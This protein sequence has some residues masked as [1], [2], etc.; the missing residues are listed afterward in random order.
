MDLIKV[1]NLALQPQRL[2]D[3][4]PSTNESRFVTAVKEPKIK[5]C[6]INNFKGI[7]RACILKVGIRSQNLPSPEEWAVLQSHALLNYGNHTCAEIS[8]AFDMAITGKLDVEVNAYESFS[9]LYFSN[10]MNAYR[11]WANQV[12]FYKERE[13]KPEQKL[14]NAP[15][16]TDDEII[17]LATEVWNTTKN[18]AFLPVKAYGALGRKGKL[19]FTDEEKAQ[20]RNQAKAHVFKMYGDKEDRISEV[21]SFAKKIAVSRVLYLINKV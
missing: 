4:K 19:N 6:D 1:Q 10:I 16:M 8:L 11:V 9:C 18:F 12:A 13:V 21:D 17:A 3:L 14:L 15:P 5:D 7:L 20:I 2:Q